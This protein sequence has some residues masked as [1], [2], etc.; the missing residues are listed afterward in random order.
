MSNGTRSIFETYGKKDDY[1]DIK[2]K[3]EGTAVRKVI[4]YGRPDTEFGGV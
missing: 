1:S 2:I 4:M 3:P